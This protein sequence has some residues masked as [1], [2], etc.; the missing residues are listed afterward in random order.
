MIEE[1][2]IQTQ[3]ASCSGTTVDE[4]DVLREVLGERRGH[5][6]GI[7]RKVRGVSLSPGSASSAVGH[8]SDQSATEVAELRQTVATLGSQLGSALATINDLN[9]MFAELSNLVPGFQ[10]RRSQP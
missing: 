3:E 1:K 5:V 7:G 4:H 2:E 8:G 6:R 9:A 10:M